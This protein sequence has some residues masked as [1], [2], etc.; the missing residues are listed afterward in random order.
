[1][2]IIIVAA[3][4]ENLVIGKNNDLAWH[5]PADLA[6]FMETIENA[7]LITGRKS[8]ESAQG[9]EVFSNNRNFIIITRNKQYCP[10]NGMV[11]NSLGEAL[12]IA[13]ANH[14]KRLCILGGATI[15]QQAMDIA[16]SMIITEVHEYF[17]GDT[18]FPEIDKNIWRETSRM[19]FSKDLENPYDY[20]FVT[21]QK[22][23]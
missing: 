5:L 20:S 4:S 22:N 1:M 14:V 16:D 17:E 21:Y 8:Y 2:Q 15:Y 9:G 19:S 3:V 10:P 11:A 6:F 13:K 23:D 7:W 12:V 18:F